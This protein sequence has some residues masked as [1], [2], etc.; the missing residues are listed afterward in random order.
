MF[1]SLIEYLQNQGK[2]SCACVSPHT[3]VNVLV[4]NGETAHSSI[5]KPRVCK[6]TFTKQGT[7]FCSQRP[8]FLWFPISRWFLY[9]LSGFMS[10]LKS[11]EVSRERAYVVQTLGPGNASKICST[12]VIVDFLRLTTRTLVRERCWRNLLFLSLIGEGS[13]SAGG[14]KGKQWFVLAVLEETISQLVGFSRVPNLTVKGRYFFFLWK[15]C[16]PNQ[17]GK[18]NSSGNTK[19]GLIRLCLYEHKWFFRQSKCLQYVPK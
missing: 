12:K 11:S 16:V 1:I 17:E 19:V 18:F 6:S 9:D 8:N 7:F 2:K 10:T 5:L 3:K 13:G 15:H 4:F 14:R